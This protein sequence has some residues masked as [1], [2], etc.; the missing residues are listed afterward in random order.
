[1]Q[2][3]LSSILVV[4][5]IRNGERILA[6]EIYRCLKSLK[7]FQNVSFYIVESDSSDHTAKV[8]HDLKREIKNFNYIEMGEVRRK[9]PEQYERIA[10]CRNEYV[11]YIRNLDTCES[12]DYV[13]VVDLDGMNSALNNK[14]IS[15]C[16]DRDDW[17][18]VTANQSFGYYD[19]LALRCNNWQVNDWRDDHQFYRDNLVNSVFVKS[20]YPK[21]IKRYFDLD[22][23]KYLAI[24]SK[25][26]RI[27]KSH[28]WI[29][30]ISGFG[31]AAI[32]KK[33]V[34]LKFDYSKVSD[35][36]EIDHVILNRKL[37]QSGGKIFINPYFINSHI[38]IYNINKI[39][40]VRTIRELIWNSE[41]I[42]NSKL[43][44][45]L[46]NLKFYT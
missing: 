28:D 14:S 31:G 18:A 12:P 34:F 8:L 16:F 32:Y 20:F 43:Y 13:M 10:Y 29:E 26:V 46:K 44:K 4:G 24:Y 3:S 41:L 39:F 6:K 1:M 7:E 19:I 17:D 38:N 36:K 35:T 22:K 27:P 11:R 37:T 33:E 42:Y 23:T 9:L 45:R 30:V 40:L 5:T 21:K 15:S 2:R 25:M